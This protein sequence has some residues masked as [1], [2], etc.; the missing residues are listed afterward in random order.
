MI[1]A[2]LTRSCAHLTH[3]SVGITKPP[4]GITSAS[5]VFQKTISKL[6]AGFRATDVIGYDINMGP[7]ETK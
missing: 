6:L 3:Y 1:L 2:N 7:V 5:D 4:F